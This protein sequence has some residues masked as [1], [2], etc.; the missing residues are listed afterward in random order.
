MGYDTMQ[1]CTGGNDVITLNI[2]IIPV[3][4]YRRN[5][6]DPVVSMRHLFVHFTE[7]KLRRLRPLTVLARLRRNV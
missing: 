3:S 2:P 5:T 4:Q 1:F 7:S 6:A